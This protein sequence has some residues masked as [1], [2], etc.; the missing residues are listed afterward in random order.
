[1]GVITRFREFKLHKNVDVF[2][3]DWEMCFRFETLYQGQLPKF[4]KRVA[5][6]RAS[7]ARKVQKVKA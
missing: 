2:W 3:D 1:M 7:R 4:P 5:A 6:K